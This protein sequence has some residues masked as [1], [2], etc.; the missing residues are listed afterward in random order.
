VFP[1]G[2]DFIF[3]GWVFPAFFFALSIKWNFQKAKKQGFPAF[4]LFKKLIY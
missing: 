2:G 1:L 4:F 3:E